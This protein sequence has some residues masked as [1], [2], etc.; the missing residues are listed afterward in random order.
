[1]EMLLGSYFV[2]PKCNK[3]DEEVLQFRYFSNNTVSVEIIFEQKYYNFQTF[4][5]S[6]ARALYSS[7]IL[8]V[9]VNRICK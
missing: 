3:V 1:M 6:S 2:F 7:Y 4:C 8:G 9:I 5:C